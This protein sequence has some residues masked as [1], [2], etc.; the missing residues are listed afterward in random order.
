MSPIGQPAD[1]TLQRHREKTG[2]D[3]TASM[4]DR[5]STDIVEWLRTYAAERIESATIDERRCSRSHRSGPRFAESLRQ[6]P[7]PPNRA[8]A[9][10]ASRDVEL[11]RIMAWITTNTL[12]TRR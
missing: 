2:G 9:P 5:E 8:R 6:A 7:Q 11:Q 12:P 3:A 1:R 10:R 4:I